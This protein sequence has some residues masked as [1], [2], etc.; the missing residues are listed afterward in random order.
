[1]VKR[2][3]KCKQR[4]VNHPRDWLQ[5]T[6]LIYGP[7]HSSDEWKGIYDFGTK[8]AKVR[9]FKKRSQEPTSNKDIG[10]NKDVN[11]IVQQEV[12]EII[13]QENK[14]KIKS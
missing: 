11:A 9:N 1:M 5:L 13:L 3:G 8:Y 7:G 4:Y 10:K 2:A 14:N 12:D 6:Y